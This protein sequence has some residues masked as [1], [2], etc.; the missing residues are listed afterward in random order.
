LHGKQAEPVGW[1]LN[2]WSLRGMNDY[3]K[4]MRL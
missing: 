4:I 3:V 1:K 2:N